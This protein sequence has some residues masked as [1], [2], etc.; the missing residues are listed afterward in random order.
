VVVEALQDASSGK[1]HGAVDSL[2]TASVLPI[3][4]AAPFPTFQNVNAAALAGIIQAQQIPTCNAMGGFVI[5]RRDGRFYD[6][7]LTEGTMTAV[8]PVALLGEGE[9]T[10][11][12]FHTHPGCNS[13]GM[14]VFSAAEVARARQLGLISYVGAAEHRVIRFDPK[15]DPAFPDGT[16]SGQ[17]L[18]NQ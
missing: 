6:S 13:R 14:S 8:S 5:E 12:E 17:V 4:P 9:R 11:A 10:V 7:K 16:S 1:P 3:S 2:L 15:H 18:A